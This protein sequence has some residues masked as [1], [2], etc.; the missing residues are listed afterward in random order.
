L[1]TCTWKDAAGPFDE[2]VADQQR[3]GKKPHAFSDL[4]GTPARF[5]ESRIIHNLNAGRR[6]E[7]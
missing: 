2:R 4:P 6:V 3:G 5:L 1:A 7:G